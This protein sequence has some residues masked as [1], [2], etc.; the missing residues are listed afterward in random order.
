MLRNIVTEL[1]EKFFHTHHTPELVC[2]ILTL[3][4]GKLQVG[5]PSNNGTEF[6]WDNVQFCR[7]VNDNFNCL[8]AFRTVNHSRC[9]P[10][11]SHSCFGIWRTFFA[12]FLRGDTNRGR[13]ASPVSRLLKFHCSNSRLKTAGGTNTDDTDAAGSLWTN[14]HEGCHHRRV[15]SQSQRSDVCFIDSLGNL[16]LHLT[17]DIVSSVHLR[18][19]HHRCCLKMRATHTN[20]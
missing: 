6:W 5:N 7:N 13:H 11:L 12:V 20:S 14:L 4:P 9:P 18:L 19:E 3:V 10:F 17:L 1:S 8:F 15:A 2:V 16:L